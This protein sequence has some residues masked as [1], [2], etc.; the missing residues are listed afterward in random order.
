MLAAIAAV[1]GTD[2][3]RV[4]HLQDPPQPSPDQ[5]LVKTVRLGICGT[6][7]D[8]LESRQPAVPPGEPFL[9]LGHEC[10]GE[11]VAVGSAVRDWQVGDRVVPL[12][13]RPRFPSA[14][15]P[16]F[17]PLGKFVERGIFYEHGFS[18]PLWLDRPEYLVRVPQELDHLAV[19]TEP[20]AVVEK[21]IR[22]ATLLQS[23][24]LGD[25]AW[26]ATGPRVLV[27]GLGPIA[28]AA[29]LACRVRGWTVSVYGRASSQQRRPLLV[30]RFG[31]RYVPDTTWK[32]FLEDVEQ[33]GFDLLLEC[34][35]S[36]E[37]LVRTSTALA[38]CGV[39]V[40]LGSSRTAEERPLNVDRLMRH[41]VIRNHLHLGTVNAARTDFESALADLQ[42]SRQ[43]FG[44]LVYEIF[45]D[46][47]RLGESLW[48]F[49]H[50][51]PE[52]I[53]TVVVYS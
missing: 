22:E 8:I 21:A 1:P 16:D 14:R 51:G 39:A 28:F 25:A 50:R 40:W 32:D 18:A 46:E 43:R 17:L 23:A 24:R 37:V 35:G 47:V 36:A 48:H 4:V 2:E 53:K 33:E 19:F 9:V 3:P 44:E 20:L 12:V 11:I 29:L 26:P 15:R 41:A 10:L 7:R 5:V 30:E 45:T 34:T 13:R 42:T 27:T 38:S 52:S 49:R 31:G 6:D